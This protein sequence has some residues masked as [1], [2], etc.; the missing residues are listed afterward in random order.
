MNFTL[1]SRAAS[2][3]KL[4]IPNHLLSSVYSSKFRTPQPSYFLSVTDPPG[5]GVQ[6]PQTLPIS[7]LDHNPT[8]SFAFYS[9]PDPHPLTLLESHRSKNVG[10]ILT[11]H[12]PTPT[13]PLHILPPPNLV[14]YI[15]ISLPTENSMP[16]PKEL[17]DILV[18]PVCK[19]PIDPLPDGSGL[20]CR[21]CR[22]VYPI[23][24]DIP[25]M[26]PEEATVAPE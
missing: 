11:T 19:T 2:T 20:K 21:S 24:D 6:T 13:R 14:C 15:P 3:R 7:T 25:V 10:A 22:R 5:V 17:L 4:L 23:K 12:Y 1:N 9:V 16:I 8:N 26:L 18:C